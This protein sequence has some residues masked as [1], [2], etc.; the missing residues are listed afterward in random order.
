MLSRAWGTTPAAL[1]DVTREEWDAMVE[2]LALEAERR[3]SA[4]LGGLRRG[5]AC[6]SPAVPGVEHGPDA[7][8]PIEHEVST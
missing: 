7:C 4:E 3:E 1:R 2:L 5:C 8:G 6:G